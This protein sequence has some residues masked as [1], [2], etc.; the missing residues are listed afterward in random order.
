M[1]K[2]LSQRMLGNLTLSIRLNKYLA[3]IDDRS[4]K[5]REALSK[6]DIVVFPTVFLYQEFSKWGFQSKEVIISEHGIDATLFKDFK[7]KPSK[8]IRFAFIGAIIPAKGLDVLLKAWKKINSS[9]AELRIYGNFDLDK[10]YASSLKSLL[11]GS[12]SIKLK[13]T[14]KPEEIA[15]VF[16]E[17]DILVL[18]SRWFENGPLVLRNSLLGKIPVIA[19]NLGSNPEYINDKVNGLL[20]FNDD[21]NDL[22]SKLEFIIN[23]PTQIETMAVKIG[24]QK[25]IKQD[26]LNL[27]GSYEKLLKS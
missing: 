11:S 16:S 25:S 21:E 10:K 4:K 8:K 15:Q 5:M 6:M 24:E 17:V 20:F 19:A 12:E 27:L 1:V 9:K 3:M 14:F 7:K 2:K 13:G 22:A 26:V 23:N 18:P